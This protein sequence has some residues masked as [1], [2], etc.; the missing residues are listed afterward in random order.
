[1]LKLYD[2]IDEFAKPEPG[3][4]MFVDT[5]CHLDFKDFDIDRDAVVKRAIEE[6]LKIIVNPGVD[7][8]SSIKALEISKRFDCVYATCGFHPHN[9]AGVKKDE[10]DR[11]TKLIEEKKVVGIGETGLDFYYNHSDRISQVDLFKRHI[12]LAAQKDLPIIVHQRNAEHEIIEVFESMKHP[13]RVVFHCFSGDEKL[14]EWVISKGFY[15]SFT[16]I[17]TFKNARN[18]HLFAQKVPLE[19]VFF[20][21]DAPFLAPVPF[22]GKRNEPGFVRFIIEK[23]SNIRKISVDELAEISSENAMKFFG[24][25]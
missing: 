12:Q 22:R 7:L 11:C 1:M 19:K 3:A 25:K 21:T 13:S 2:A 20:E 18:L 4:I 24:I 15:I 14:F 16:G 8:D 6:K 9:A 5:H 17:L 23:F 10:F